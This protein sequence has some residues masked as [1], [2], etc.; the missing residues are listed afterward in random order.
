M[1]T[2]TEVISHAVDLHEYLVQMPPP[3]P[4][5]RLHRLYPAFADLGGEHRT[6]PVPPE[7]DRFAAHIDTALM[8]QVL[9]IPKRE[10]KADVQHH[11]HAND[12]GRRFEIADG[13]A[14]VMQTS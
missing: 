8:Q 12:L 2:V 6:K 11:R 14:V 9:D 1:A 7:P 10:G 3:P 4:P 5:A 13:A